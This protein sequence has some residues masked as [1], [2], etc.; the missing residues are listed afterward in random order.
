MGPASQPLSLTRRTFLSSA[1][2]A[3]PL[4]RV[5]RRV[6]FLAASWLASVEAPMRDLAAT[7][8]PAELGADGAARVAR[9]FQRWIDGYRENAELV[10]GYGTSA[11]EFTKP[12]P[13]A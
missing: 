3:F 2:S 12:S 10:H 6:D 5:A 8:L 1:V 7:V 11:L 4:A 9:A 13:R